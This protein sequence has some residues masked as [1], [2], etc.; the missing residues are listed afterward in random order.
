MFSS[1]YLPLDAVNSAQGYRQ[2]AAQKQLQVF[3]SSHFVDTCRDDKVVRISARHFIY[4]Y[5]VLNCFDYFYDAVEPTQDEGKSVVDYSTPR[6]HKLIG[7]DLFPVLIPS[8]AEP[9]VTCSQYLDFAC[10]QEGDVVFDL[11]AYSGITAMAFAEK[12]GSSGKVIAVEPDPQNQIALEKNLSQYKKLNR[13]SIDVVR[14][15]IWKDCD[16]ISFSSE[17]NMGSSAVSIV[18]NQR[19][20]V[21]KSPSI[22]LDELARQFSLSHVSFIK[23][24]VEGAE[25]HIFDSD[26][27]QKFRPKIIVEPH[28]YNI[29]PE[30]QAP[31]ASPAA[32]CDAVAKHVSERLKRF[33]YRTEMI[34]QTGVNMPLLCAFP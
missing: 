8:L 1:L 13:L 10:L 14:S 3:I 26:F 9:Y 25:V 27:L 24:D 16:G 32:L 6:Y 29:G 30:R 5:D 22:T 20:A 4:L 18:G 23:C 31:S 7:F 15:A 33:G 28:P 17:G 11:G 19:G 21:V 2:V 12:V 34:K